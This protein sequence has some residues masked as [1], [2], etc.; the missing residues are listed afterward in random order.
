MKVFVFLA[1]FLPLNFSH[2]TTKLN[3]NL[4]LTSVG[5]IQ[6]TKISSKHWFGELP[7]SRN[8]TKLLLAHDIFIIS[9]DVEKRFP[10]WVAYHL[11][12]ALVW[13]DL[14]SRRKYV[15][16]PFLSPSQSL[17]FKDYRG[18]SN[19]DGKNAGYDKGHLAPVGS[20]KASV[21]AYQAQYLSNIVPQTRK[22][23]QGPWRKLEEQV[24]DF[25]KRGNEVRILTGPVFGKDGKDKLPPCWRAA[26]GK[27][28]EIPVSYWKIIAFK[29]RS[30]VKACSFLMPQNIK[31]QRDRPKK[32]KVKLE[33]IE[34]KTNLNLLTETKKAVLQDCSFLL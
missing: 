21:Y 7:L 18:A 29:Y 34:E 5:Q 11:S 15:L 4:S 13:G 33:Q 25:V 14:K 9:F 20:F 30:K 6:K 1:C 10:S 24:R 3:P 16:D 2:A 12:P 31:N 32:Y 23:N 22:L 27:L 19:C 8:S 28:E 26:Q 17:T